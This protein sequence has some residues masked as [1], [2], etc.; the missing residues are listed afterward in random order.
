MNGLAVVPPSQLV[1]LLPTLN[2][3][4][5]VSATIADLPLAD[6]RALGF[7]PKV[8]VVDGHS[9]DATVAVAESA[10][11]TVITQRGKGKGAAVREGMDWAVA[12]GVPYVVVL[13]ADHTYTGS[14]LTAM[15]TLLDAGSDMVIGVRRPDRHALSTIRGLVHR[16]GNAGLNFLAGYLSGGPVL[17]VCSG[18]WGIRT[19]ILAEMSLVS[20]GFDIEAEA[21]VKGF[22]LG[23]A[24]SQL[25]V[26]YR[27]RIG[28][29]KLHAF[30]D[31]SRI[32]LSIL[33]YSTRL[34]PYP[35][36]R[37]TTAPVTPDVLP[38]TTVRDLQSVL[39]A[40]KS[41]RVF[42]SAA[43]EGESV[44]DEVVRR[45][46]GGYPSLTVE[47]S[48]GG[49]EGRPRAPE[50]SKSAPSFAVPQGE[51]WTIVIDLPSRP[52]HREERTANIQIPTGQRRIY[53][54][55]GP[56]GEATRPTLQGTARSGVYKLERASL[57]PLSSLRLLSSS[58]AQF[59]H[60]RDLALISANVAHTDV[61]VFRERTKK[62][63]SEGSIGQ[64]PDRPPSSIDGGAA[65]NFE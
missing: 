10:G 24:I 52:V 60:Q 21:F 9:T 39:F 2:E 57:R 59:G 12:R 15:A 26:T 36:G 61:A 33:R 35:K 54:D 34:D 28:T 3:E 46:G 51:P 45:L 40:L 20:E 31:G 19:S 56:Q 8:L 41:P 16:L 14:A 42:V 4:E 49:T 43:P 27:D 1:I 18:L 22:R 29:A 62:P 13:D 44:V 11:A 65:V 25:P 50:F 6:V 55:F 58:L 63:S 48:A 38:G 64:C 30:A 53:I 17:D 37:P 7:E 5:G 32:L 47:K 23:L